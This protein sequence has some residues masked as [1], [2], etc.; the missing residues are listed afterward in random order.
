[1]RIRRTIFTSLLIV[2]FACV[3]AFA[4]VNLDVNGTQLKPTGDYL[5]NEGVT[6]VEAN[7]INTITGADVNVNGQDIVIVKNND[8]IKLTL[9]Q[10]EALLNEKPLT[11]TATPYVNNNTIMLPLR[12]VA[13]ALGAEI[14]WNE[15]SRTVVINY[16]ETRNDLTAEELIVKTSVVLNELPTYDMD[17]NMQMQIKM[18]GI[19]ED[20]FPV[21][22][23]M[24]SEFYAHYEKEPLVVYSKQVMDVKGPADMPPELSKMEVEAVLIGD[25]YYINTPETGWVKID[26]SGLNLDDLMQSLNTQD[27]SAMLKQ[28]QNFGMIANFGND[29]ELEGQK[30]WVVNVVIDKEKFINE[31]KKILTTLPIPD[32]QELNEGIDEFLNNTSFDIS[33]TNYINPATLMT[34]FMDMDIDMEM[35]IPSPEENSTEVLNMTMNMQGKFNVKKADPNFKLPDISSAE[36]LTNLAN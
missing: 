7:L 18:S 8:T 9:G 36:D 17:G 19:E 11:L 27:A 21:D 26:L 24:N 23:S 35:A 5:L 6:F 3:P 25:A 32:V 12:S 34:D 29:M 2:L 15:N 13:E 20:G 16:L 33:Y 30:Y 28:M 1:M 31:Y 14:G 4:N 22:M 10:K